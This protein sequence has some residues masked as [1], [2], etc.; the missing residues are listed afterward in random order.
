MK[1]YI[2]SNVLKASVH[3]AAKKD[4]RYY[5]CG[6]LF[7][8]KHGFFSKLEIISTDGHVMS[9]FSIP[10]DYVDNAQT[11]DFEF[12]IPI[13]AIKLALKGSAKGDA[14]ILESLPDG[15]Y[16]L[17]D[18]IFSPIDGKFPDYRRFIPLSNQSDSEK[19]LNFNV[20][21]LDKAQSAM[22][23]FFRKP[24]GIYTVTHKSGAGIMHNG[25]NDAVCV[26]MPIRE[27]DCAYQGL[28]T[29]EP[30]SKAA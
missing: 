26:V 16:V 25:T 24:D 2:T 28:Y 15:R 3:C 20:D 21:L 8:F 23:D 6:V 17:G 4:T 11:A 30:L 18:I 14:L 22:R 27:T 9:A 10:L 13:D 7:A 12:I 5:L 29:V 1:T 19:P